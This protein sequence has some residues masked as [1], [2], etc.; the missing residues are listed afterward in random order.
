MEHCTAPRS[1]PD[2]YWA[3]GTALCDRRSSGP[4][5]G[6][7]R[8]LVSLRR[9]R[10]DIFKPRISETG[11]QSVRGYPCMLSAGTGVEQASTRHLSPTL[12]A[13]WP[14]GV[15]SIVVTYS[16]T[17]SEELA[18]MGHWTGARLLPTPPQSRG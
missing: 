1:K 5:L 6:N 18:R 12:L 7:F 15:R 4:D 2:G 11:R 17:A 16:N 14:L 8:L 13:S 3:R 9:A 10:P